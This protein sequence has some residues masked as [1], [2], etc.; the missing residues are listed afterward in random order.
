MYEYHNN[1]LSIPAK[2]L[3]EDWALISYTNYKRLCSKGKL[4]NT[5]KGKGAGNEAFVSF[6]DLPV[7]QGVDFKKVCVENLKN[8][9]DVIVRNQLE[10]YILP[11]IKAA[12]FFAEHRKPNGRSLSDED[13]REKATNAMILNGIQMLFNDP[14]L[15]KKAFGTK[16]TMVWNEVS[17]AVNGINPKRWTF[18]LPGNPRR[19]KAKYDDYLKNGYEVF[20]HKG[21]GQKNAQIIKDEIADFLLAKY[22]LPIKKSIPEV[23]ADYDKEAIKRGWKDL[24][25]QGIYNWLYQPEQERIWTLARHGLSAYNKKYKHTI[26]RDRSDWFPNAYWAIDGTKL[27]WI[28]YWDDSSNKMGAKLK[29]DVMFDVYSEKII[30]WDLSF[31]ESHIE[32]FK[33]IKMAVNESQCRP[34]YLTYDHQGGHKMDRMQTLYDSLMAVEG[35]G[36]HHPNKARNH[37]NPSEQ[38]FQRFQQQVVTKFWFSDGQGVTVRRDDNKMNVDFILENKDHLKTVEELQKAWQAAVNIWNNKQHPKFEASRNEVYQHQMPMQEPLTLWD[39]MD[40]MW[41]EETK[42]LVTYKSS[43]MYLKIGGEDYEFEVYDKTGAVD[44]DFRYKNIGKKFKVRYDPDFLDG[45]VQLYDKDGKGNFVWVANAEPKRKHQNIPALMKEG[46]KESWFADMQVRKLELE[47]T[48]RELKA[49]EDRTGINRQSLIEDTDLMIKMGGN[50]TKVEQLITEA[51]DQ[52]Y[53]F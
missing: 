16:S 53:D 8:P 43:G 52:E 37:S 33:A 4:V 19:L 24:T 6:H 13:Q 46:H 22:C 12:K 7:H 41:I 38:L 10:A 29:I 15:K 45:Y 26:T 39:I 48:Q 34:Y 50:M 14:K 28:H 1:I 30:G 51:V 23:L 31:T 9:K 5:K 18:S 27:D 3:Y 42:R 11:D 2:L 25:E 21:E 49:L 20:L 40:K 17:I 35:H 44:L 32:H 36:T 47:R